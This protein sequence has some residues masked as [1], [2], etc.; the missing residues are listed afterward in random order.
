[1]QISLPT[2]REDWKKD[3]NSIINQSLLSVNPYQCVSEVIQLK[4]DDLFISDKKIDL[5]KIDEIY[6]IGVGKAVVQ[7]ARAM[8]DKIG[9]RITTGFLI[10]KHQIEKEAFVVLI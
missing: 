3:I 4:G 5:K 1:M 8:I 7:M 6:L 2:I 9:K 10:T